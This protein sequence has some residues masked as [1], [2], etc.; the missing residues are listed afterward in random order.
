ML[1]N[2]AV[3]FIIASTMTNKS[4][5]TPVEWE[6]MQAVWGLEGPATVRD[7]LEH[8]YPDGRRYRFAVKSPIATHLLRRD[9]MEHDQIQH[10]LWY[11]CG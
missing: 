5:L 4:K 3:K 9:T 6:V 10:L 11:I 2:P 1:V 8:L 7:I